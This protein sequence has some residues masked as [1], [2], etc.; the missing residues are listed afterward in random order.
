MVDK[1]FVDNHNDQQRLHYRDFMTDLRLNFPRFPF[2]IIREVT[3]RILFTIGVDGRAFGMNL[4]FVKGK[5][6]RLRLLIFH[7]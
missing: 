3:A 5:L 4:S 1:C 7:C 6:L 2:N